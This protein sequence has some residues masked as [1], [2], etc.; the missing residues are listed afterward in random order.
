VT[1]AIF[2]AGYGSSSRL[3]EE[4][5]RLLG[6]TPSSG[7]AGGRNVRIRF[8]VRESSLGAVLVAATDR[9]ICAIELGDDPQALVRNLQDRF[10]NAE[11]IGGD[12][13]FEQLVARIVAQVEHPQSDFALPL[14]V[15]GTAFQH[16]VWQA[17]TRIPLGSTATYADLARAIGQPSAVR[18]VAQAC[19][20]NPVALAIPCHRVIRT[21]ASLSGY[22]WGVERKRTLLERERRARHR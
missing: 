20:A 10:P 12:A 22:R 17:L 3:Y 7:R 9:G 18:A 11:I 21:D 8:A 15:R 4:A 2:A 13:A 6:M 1:R 16:R 5:E 19:G 14:D